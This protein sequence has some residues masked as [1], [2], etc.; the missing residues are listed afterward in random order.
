MAVE[1][2]DGAGLAVI[3]K[4]TRAGNVD[5]SITAALVRVL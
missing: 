3:L 2:G 5:K 4:L 1:V